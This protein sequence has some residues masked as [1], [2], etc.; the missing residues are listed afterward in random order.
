MV[1][2]NS[3]LVMYTIKILFLFGDSNTKD[4]VDWG[5][6]LIIISGEDKT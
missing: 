4:G 3:G 6:L 1:S 2:L 5:Y